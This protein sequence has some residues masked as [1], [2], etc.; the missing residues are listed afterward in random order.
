MPVTGKTERRAV[1]RPRK[2]GRARLWLIRLLAVSFSLVVALLLAEGLL[3]LCGY[4]DFKGVAYTMPDEELSHVNK[5]LADVDV[6][7]ADFRYRVRI[8]AMGFRGKKLRSSADVRILLIGDSCTFGSGVDDDET[9]AFH[10]QRL[11]NEAG[12]ERVE[13]INA[14]VYGYGALQ[15]KGLALRV[16]DAIKPDI[17]VFTHCGNDFADDLRHLDG[18]YT[19]LRNSIP[20]RRFLREHSALYNTLKPKVL[21]LLS[22]MGIYNMRLR[23]EAPGE[24]GLVSD[25]GNLWQKGRDTTCAAVEDLNRICAE[26]G[27]RFF[28]TSVGFSPKDQGIQFS[29]DAQAV[30]GFCQ[31]KGIA[32]LDPRVAFLTRLTEPWHNDTSVG[33]FSPLGN[34]LFSKSLFLGL[35][36]SDV[37]NQEPTPEPKNPA[38]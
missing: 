1:R 9:F 35:T 11:L 10:L 18:R 23:F 6:R 8:N 29:T 32:F 7:G 38:G 37:L 20:G 16:W 5:P 36:T 21:S 14:G 12:N 30:K 4:S 15:A 28:V 34:R 3:R 17:V 25:L 13:V 22:A 26:R 19:Q 33:H 2:G 31:T 27:A 24:G